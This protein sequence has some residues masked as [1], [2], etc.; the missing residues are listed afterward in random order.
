MTYPSG[1]GGLPEDTYPDS[2]DLRLAEIQRA[3]A[4]PAKPVS[5][6]AAWLKQSAPGLIQDG[7]VHGWGDEGVNKTVREAPQWLSQKP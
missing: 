6:A 4:R 3:A 1:L 7:E 2:E 5:A